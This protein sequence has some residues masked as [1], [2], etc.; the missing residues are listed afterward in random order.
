MTET[1]EPMTCPDSADLSLWPE[2]AAHGDP[3][4][5]FSL[6]CRFRFAEP[7]SPRKVAAACVIE[8]F[9]VIATAVQVSA[10]AESPHIDS[11]GTQF[12]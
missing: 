3:C 6:R 2:L 5:A 12:P 8:Q 11:V 4:A 9:F 10:R 1:T 7:R